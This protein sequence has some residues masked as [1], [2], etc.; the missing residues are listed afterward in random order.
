MQ[1]PLLI[2]EIEAALVSG[3]ERRIEM[4][5]RIAELFVSGAA[6]YSEEQIGLFDDIMVRLLSA[7]DADA[8]AQIARRL[9]PLANAP[10]N[11]IHL[12]AFDD[13]IEVARP[14]LSQSEGLEDSA[15]RANA[16]TK[17]QQHLLAIAQRRSLSETV[18]DVLIERG[19]REVH[20]AVVNSVGSRISEAG[21]RRL[22]AENAP[23]SASEGIVAEGTARAAAPHFAAVP[24]GTQNPNRVGRIGEAELY[25]FARDRKFEETA[26][27][28]SI[29]CD[30]PIDLVERALADPTAEIILILA[31]VG[32]LSSATTKALL[33]LRA[34]DRSMSA[35]DI[36]RAL[37]S[38]ERLQPTTARRVLDFFRTRLKKP[39]QPLISPAMAANL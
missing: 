36:D 20:R 4:L 29:L 31:K 37:L 18:T 9:A 21:W 27:A 2:A 5:A 34:A 38:F 1:A 32:G 26:R 23:G 6:R 19:D 39:A 10:S 24:A 16:A 3:T 33:L 12:L 28:L 8:R 11:L 15:L 30:T 22:A 17:S 7:V 14:V 25:R 35:T 13:D